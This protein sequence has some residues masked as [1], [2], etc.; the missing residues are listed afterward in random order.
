MLQVVGVDVIGWR[1]CG[2][3]LGGIH[4][5]VGVKRGKSPI[6]R[7]CYRHSTWREEVRFDV[8]GYGKVGI[9]VV[10]DTG[11]NGCETGIDVALA[12]VVAWLNCGVIVKIV[13]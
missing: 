13:G 7:R 10:V 9:D 1:A 5:D 2:E 11:W 12:D 3:E 6:T 4:M 8:A